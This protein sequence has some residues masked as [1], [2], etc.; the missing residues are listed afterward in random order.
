MP[1][2]DPDY[3]PVLD[4]H[5]DNIAMQYAWQNRNSHPRWNRRQEL[6]VRGVR[7]ICR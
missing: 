3:P 7:H 5:W 1:E 2:T 4:F 6:K